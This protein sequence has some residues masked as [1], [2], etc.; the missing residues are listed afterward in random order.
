VRRPEDFGK[1]VASAVAE[2]AAAKDGAAGGGVRGGASCCCA[3]LTGT[4]K[5]AGGPDGAAD[6]DPEDAMMQKM[7][8]FSTF[9]SSKVRASDALCAG[10]RC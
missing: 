9:D 5:Q 8:G 6:I 1:V 2:S 3:Q 7:L 10:G 4:A